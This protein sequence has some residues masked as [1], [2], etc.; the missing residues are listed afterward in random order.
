MLAVESEL[1]AAV[2]AL[3]KEGGADA[4]AASEATGE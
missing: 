1:S 2:S 3:A 4:N